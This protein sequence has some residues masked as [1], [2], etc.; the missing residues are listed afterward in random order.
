MRRTILA[1]LVCSSA[2][3]QAACAQQVHFTPQQLDA[4]SQQ[5]QTELGHQNWGAPVEPS[6]PDAITK[7][8]AELG[9]HCMST[10]SDFPPV[11]AEPSETSARVGVAMSPVAA[12]AMSRD[13]WTRI[14]RAG[15]RF[16][17][18][19]SSALVP[20]RP[21]VSGGSPRCVVDGERPNGQVQF[22]YGS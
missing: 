6:R 1:V 13:G 18:I 19:Q 17:W 20:F 16:V 21:F 9:L 10:R 3:G 12:T 7:L 4:M 8:P 2:W 14:L 5:R 15:S 11:Y 22:R